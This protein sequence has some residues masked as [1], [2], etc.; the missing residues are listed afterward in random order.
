MGNAAC[1]VK[2]ASTT[3]VG[4]LGSKMP[5]FELDSTLGKTSLYKVFGDKWGVLFSHPADFTPICTT[6]L[7]MAQ[8]YLPEFEKRGVAIAGLSCDPAESHKE[9]LKDI[10]AYTEKTRGKPHK[11]TYPIF[12]DTKREV[13]LM[14]GMIDIGHV[15]AAG[16]PLP[17][18]KVFIVDP[19]K[20]IRCTL[21]YP[22]ATGRNFDE[23]LRVI[24][25]MQLTTLKKIA[26]PANW[27]QGEDCVLLPNI[28]GEEA[29]A[30]NPT[31]L[32]LPS[33]KEYL[34]TTKCPTLESKQ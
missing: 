13:A 8:E 32:E 12:A 30:Y 34:R 20:V 18:R 16:I 7:G 26:T 1:G 25:S 10:E 11:P 6:E 24:D 31:L 19:K 28:K 14:L 4:I 17:A 5:D 29:K 21:C 33:G 2:R 27:K 23:V 22:A 15:S 9:W 3:P